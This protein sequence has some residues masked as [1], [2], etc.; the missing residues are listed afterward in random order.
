[1]NKTKIVI[2]GVGGQGVVFLSRLFA[3]VAR[4]SGD[5]LISYESHGMAMRGGSVSSQLKIGACQSP[6]ISNGEA[7]ILLVLAA[8]ELP[9]VL[10]FLRPSGQLFVNADKAVAGLEDYQPAIIP[11]SS[12]ALEHKMPQAINLILVGFATA[13]ADF[14]YSTSR[15]RSAL[16]NMP[17]KEKIKAANIAA[18]D[19][20][21]NWNSAHNR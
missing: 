10:H 9:N 11:A 3:E 5:P 4:L 7:D 1:M 6:L 14:P 15:F 17:I 16:G 20:G 2:A 18:L 12:M 19:L 8:A 13:Q 21:F